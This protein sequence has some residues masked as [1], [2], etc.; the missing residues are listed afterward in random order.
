MAEGQDESKKISVTVKT[1]K[2]KV[3]IEVAEDAEIKT[4]CVFA[5]ECACASNLTPNILYAHT[6]ILVF[7]YLI[8]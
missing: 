3:S 1:P 2:E 7:S 5:A 8:Y 4:V 6:S